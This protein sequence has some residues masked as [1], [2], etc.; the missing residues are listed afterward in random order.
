MIA[1]RH[2]SPSQDPLSQEGSL[3]YGGRWNK[4]EAFGAIYFALSKLALNAE[5]KRRMEFA[6]LTEE[7]YFPREITQVKI[8]ISKLVDFRKSD[9]RKEWGLK[10]SEIRSDDLIAC[11]TIAQRI[12]KAGFEGIVS[13]SRTGIGEN[14]AVFKENLGG[15][16]FTK[17][18]KVWTASALKEI[19]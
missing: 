6:G 2:T 11:Q 19:N 10:L 3:K 8:Q 18:E 9:I 14:I 12:I 7:M 16:S 1:Y 4:K 13:P 17:V 15:S 5:V